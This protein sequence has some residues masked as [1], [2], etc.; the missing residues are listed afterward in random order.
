LHSTPHSPAR[1]GALKSAGITSLE[2]GTELERFQPHSGTPGGRA[3]VAN[4]RREGARVLER[5]GDSHLALNPFHLTLS[6]RS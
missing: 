2:L 3:T 4:E 5:P 6:F 1:D